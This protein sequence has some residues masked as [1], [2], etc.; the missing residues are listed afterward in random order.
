MRELTDTLTQNLISLL[1]DSWQCCS[2]ALCCRLNLVAAMTERVETGA[3]QEPRERERELTD[4]TVSTAYS[5][6]PAALLLCLLRCQLV[7]QLLPNTGQVPSITYLPPSLHDK[8]TAAFWSNLPVQYSISYLLY[9]NCLQPPS[10]KLD[11]AHSRHRNYTFFT[12]NNLNTTML[13]VLG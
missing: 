9:Y 12:I 5:T 10:S 11:Q 7:C 2:A 4:C 3:I 1:E 8:T 6:K 13:T